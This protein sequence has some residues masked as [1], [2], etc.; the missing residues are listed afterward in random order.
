MEAPVND[1]N[2]FNCPKENNLS[3]LFKFNLQFYQNMVKA[4]CTQAYVV[5]IIIEG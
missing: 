2:S 1:G 4:H 5:L 3:K